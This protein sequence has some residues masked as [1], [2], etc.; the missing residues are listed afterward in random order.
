MATDEAYENATSVMSAGVTTH[1]GQEGIASFMEKR[2]PTWQN[3]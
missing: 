3:R 1:D 2:R